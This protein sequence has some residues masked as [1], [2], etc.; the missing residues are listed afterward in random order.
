MIDTACSSS[1]CSIHSAASALRN[2]E[3]DGAIVASA[4]LIVFPEQQLEVAKADTPPEVSS[5][6]ISDAPADGCGRA[7]AVNVVFL[8]PLSSALKNGDKVWAVLRGSSV[9]A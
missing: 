6:H 2:G 3:C 1:L 8:K 4:N 5:F 7:E 9:N